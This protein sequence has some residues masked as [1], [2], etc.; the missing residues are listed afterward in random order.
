LPISVSDEVVHIDSES[1]VRNALMKGPA[2][3]AN[4]RAFQLVTPAQ[5][6]ILAWV[7]LQREPR[8]LPSRGGDCEHS[9]L[10]RRRTGHH[11]P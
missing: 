5:R 11:S 9:A 8:D 3:V 10:L 1:H 4:R 6:A 2:G 7:R